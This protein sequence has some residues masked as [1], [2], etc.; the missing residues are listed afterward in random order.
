MRREPELFLL[1]SLLV[2]IL[3]VCRPLDGRCRPLFCLSFPYE[4]DHPFRAIRIA[5][6]QVSEPGGPSTA[7]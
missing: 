6:Y 3:S 1:Q 7:G 2:V 5:V 4:I